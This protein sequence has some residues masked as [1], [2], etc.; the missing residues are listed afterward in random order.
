VPSFS[1]LGLTIMEVKGVGVMLGVI[2]VCHCFLLLVRMEL[3]FRR[4]KLIMINKI[5]LDLFGE[6][7]GNQNLSLI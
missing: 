7:K 5:T 4:R 1:G 2:H 6:S 3:L